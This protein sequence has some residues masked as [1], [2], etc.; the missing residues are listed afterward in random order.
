MADL[1]SH[2]LDIFSFLT[3]RLRWPVPMTRWRAGREIRSLLENEVTRDQMTRQLFEALDMC[4]TESE[5][6]SILNLFLLTDNEA[7][8][9]RSALISHIGHPS[10][11]TDFLL[12]RMYGWGK[13]IGRWLT[14]HS[15]R[16]PLGFTQSD[17]FEEHKTAHVPPRL[18]HRLRKLEHDTDLPFVQQWAFEWQNLCER[19]GIRLTR[20][21]EYFDDDTERRAGIVGQYQLG[22][23]EA[24]RSAHIRTFSFA[25]SEWNMPQELALDEILNHIPVI[26]GLFDLE[27]IERPAWLGS[28]PQDCL[29]DP[30]ALKAVVQKFVTSQRDTDDQV[31]SFSSPFE[32]DHAR[33]GHVQLSALL[34]TENFELGD[35][36]NLFEFA[37]ICDARKKLTI[38]IEWPERPIDG[39]SFDGLSDWAI[40]ICNKLYPVPH[41]HWMDHYFST[42]IPTVA[43]YCLPGVKRLRVRNGSLEL[44]VDDI[45]VSATSVWHDSWSPHY[46]HAQD[47]GNTRN[48]VCVKVA[49]DI[50]KSV[51]N[52]RSDDLKLGWLL[53]TKV[54]D[55]EKDFDGYKLVQRQTFVFDNEI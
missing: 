52:G 2:G 45:L 5:V 30:A 24:F 21:P 35:T 15:G 18:W 55:R 23:T 13:G 37:N 26:S 33:Y 11:L 34:A 27:P 44:L 17:Y 25:V 9:E 40:P 47:I 39:S 3:Q 16:A 43:S 28:L 19:T 6:C 49:S 29:D 12:E 51:M 8:P 54:W 31:L 32:I 7:R 20:Y 38:E 50:L 22:Q 42:G 48:G 36:E 53:K 10:I 46:A 1:S 4:R 41:G 14:A